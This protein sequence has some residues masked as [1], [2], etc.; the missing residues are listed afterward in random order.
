MKIN[1]LLIF[2]TLVAT[3]LFTSSCHKHDDNTDD[4]NSTVASTMS[5]KFGSAN[6]WTAKTVKGNFNTAGNRVFLYAYPTVESTAIPGLFLQLK[7]ETGTINVSESNF[8]P[9]VNANATQ[10]IEYFENQ[11]ITL[12][13]VCYGDWWVKSGTVTISAIDRS[14]MTMTAT[15]NL[16]M[17]NAQQRYITQ[18]TQYAEK[19]LQ[20]TLNNVQITPISK[21]TA[22]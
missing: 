3:L 18:S 11:L 5:V 8:N 16:N 4:S 6:A 12:N 22:R 1:K 14:K 10:F 19:T 17:F 15:L 2:F 9:M 13:N 20:V 7:S 21:K